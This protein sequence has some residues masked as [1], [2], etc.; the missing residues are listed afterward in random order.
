MGL[1]SKQAITVI[2]YGA[3]LVLIMSWC[4]K[5]MTT[6]L[7]DGCFDVQQ[8]CDQV[9]EQAD[10]VMLMQAKAYT[11]VTQQNKQLEKE[12]FRLRKQNFDLENPPWHKDPMWTG[13]AG[14]LGGVFIILSLQK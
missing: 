2:I 12:I 1:N 6:V 13:L 9:L 3:L 5:G 4:S 10:E 7:N 11:E 14:I 8:L